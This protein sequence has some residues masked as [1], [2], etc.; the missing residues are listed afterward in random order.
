MKQ[1]RDFLLSLFSDPTFAGLPA[2]GWSLSLSVF[3]IA[4]TL[5]I[6]CSLVFLPLI[7]SRNYFQP[8]KSFALKLLLLVCGFSLAWMYLLLTNKLLFIMPNELQGILVLVIAA[9]IACSSLL[10]L[11]KLN[12]SDPR[13]E[14]DKLYRLK[15]LQPEGDLGNSDS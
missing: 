15:N 1:I 8:A 6:F 7:A 14:V 11:G 3:Y 10:L 12:G 4:C 5:S 13:F 9:L 2:D